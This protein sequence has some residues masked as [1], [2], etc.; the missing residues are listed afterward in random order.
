M[1]LPFVVL[2]R[3][4]LVLEPQ[5]DAVI[6]QFEQFKESLDEERLTPILRQAAR[7]INFYNHS[8]YDLRRL[9]QDS[10]NIEPNFNNYLNGSS[11]NVREIIENF[12]QD[13]TLSQ[14]TRRIERALLYLM[15]G[16]NGAK[17]LKHTHQ[18]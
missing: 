4:D 1:I 11:K 9:A 7:G 2:R 3:L 17:D 15:Y 12:Q 13:G 10:K 14:T 8:F 6:K 18:I 5:K 16:S